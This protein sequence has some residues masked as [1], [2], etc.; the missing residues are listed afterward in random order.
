MRRSIKS[1]IRTIVVGSTWAILALVG[2]LAME[3][4]DDIVLSA[5]IIAA[6]SS[7]A[8]LVGWLLAED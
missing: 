6:A 4:G 2:F 8:A 3:Y 5:Y 7:G 1:A